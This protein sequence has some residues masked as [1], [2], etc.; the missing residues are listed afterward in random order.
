MDSGMEED[1]DMGWIGVAEEVG[2]GMAVAVGV[3]DGATNLGAIDVVVGEAIV[4]NDAA[5]EKTIP[6][7][8]LPGSH[9]RLECY[10]LL[11]PL[12]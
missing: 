7:G 11:H 3:E 5:L 10:H 2:G 8:T 9:H 4:W 12:V 1:S 6:H